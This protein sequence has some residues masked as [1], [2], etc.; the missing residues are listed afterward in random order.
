MFDQLKDLDRETL[1]AML[2]DFAKNWLAHDG[3]WF[4]AIEQHTDMKTAIDLDT[5]AWAKFTVIEAQRI[6]ARHNIA[7]GSGLAGLKKALQFRLYAFINTQEIRNE[8]ESSF[9]F[10]M[11]DCRVQSARQR[12]QLPL[13]PCKSVGVVE[14][15]EFAHTIDP[16]IKTTVICCPPD[17]DAGKG[18]FCG[19]RFSI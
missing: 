3:L 13:F 16:R 8:T 9:D 11:V 5:R 19:W 10:Y 15:T 12:K 7:P 2:A 18:H 6:M 17:M 4:Q 1:E 14:Y